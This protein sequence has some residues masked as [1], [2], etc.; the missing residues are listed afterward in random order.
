MSN[1]KK[2]LGYKI[3]DFMADN[4]NNYHYIN[5]FTAAP[6][7]GVV[8][9]VAEKHKVDSDAVLD[10]LVLGSIVELYFN[11]KGKVVLIMP[12][13][14]PTDDILI[15]FGDKKLDDVSDISE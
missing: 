6:A 2:V 1:Y 8:G 9:L 3:G 11:D 15:A 12:V 13:L 4:G 5:L 14:D 10:G 7:D